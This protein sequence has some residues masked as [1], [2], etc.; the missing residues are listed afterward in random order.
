MWNVQENFLEV[1]I[2]EKTTG[3]DLQKR[4]PAI[5]SKSTVGLKSR[6]RLKK[7][8]GSQHQFVYNYIMFI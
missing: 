6:G 8:P 7:R 1:F 3:D 5:L 4:H 2:T